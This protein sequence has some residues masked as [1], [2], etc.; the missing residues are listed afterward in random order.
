MENNED[1]AQKLNR[2]KSLNVGISLDDFGTGYSTLSYLD[3]L[4]IDELKIDKAFIDAIPQDGEK[5]ILL[6]TIIAM[7]KTLNMTVVAEGVE[8]EYQRKYLEKKLCDIYQ[9]YLFSKPVSKQECMRYFKASS[10]M[11]R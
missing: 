10:A 5:N 9:G 3:K 8:H 11:L 7:G 6:D 1:M 2:I 4:S